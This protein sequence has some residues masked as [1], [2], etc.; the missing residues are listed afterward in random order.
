VYVQVQEHCCA[1]AYAVYIIGGALA[2][3][4]LGVWMVFIERRLFRVRR[5]VLDAGRMGL[6]PL[7]ILHVTDT[8]FCGH[9]GPILAFLERLS[10]QEQFDLLVL[11]GDLIDSRAGVASAARTAAFFKPRLGAFGV[12]GGHDY[13]SISFVRAYTHIF[14]RDQRAVYAAPNPAAELVA[15]LEQSGVKVLED[16]NVL[17][18]APDGCR[19]AVIAL[20]D[21]FVFE[22][23]F[24]AAWHGVDGE[25]PAIVI[26]HSPDVL[27]EARARGAALAF[28][29]HT[30]GGQVRLPFVG[31]L[32]TRSHLPR[33]LAS[34]L[35]RW[36]KT[37]FCINNGLGASPV[38]PYRLFCRPEVTV[39]ELAPSGRGAFTPIEE[40]DLG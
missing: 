37:V 31:A 20:R 8:H 24:R 22:P 25:T 34:G 21:A 12:L 19:F 26:A 17:L 13:A 4:L 14:A 32:V 33:R 35:F 15:R 9:D 38:V 3:A 40:V 2:C 16:A 6:P 29:G 36:G 5:V 27:P 39:A 28:L 18:T 10:S 23:D 1:V 30:H 7:R 11:T